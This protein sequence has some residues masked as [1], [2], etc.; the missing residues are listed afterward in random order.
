VTFVTSRACWPSSDLLR[1]NFFHSAVFRK[2]GGTSP[3]PQ[4]SSWF[5]SKSREQQSKPT[6]S[7]GKKAVEAKAAVVSAPAS[8]SPADAAQLVFAVLIDAKEPSR[9]AAVLASFFNDQWLLVLCSV[10]KRFR[11]AFSADVFWRPRAIARWSE[12]S[13]AT[14]IGQ[15]PW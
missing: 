5:R 4:M 3:C 11:L 10:S 2:F 14:R 12:L 13:M 6:T 1:C 15:D 7:D 9:P 8:Q